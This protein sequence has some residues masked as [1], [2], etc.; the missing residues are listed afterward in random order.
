MSTI[1]SWLFGFCAANLILLFMPVLPPALPTALLAIVLNI[2]F[3]GQCLNRRIFLRSEQHAI[4]P[5][6]LFVAFAAGSIS[7]LVS[8]QSALP[9]PSV[10]QAL[11]AKPIVVIEG[12]VVSARCTPAYH[13]YTISLTR[14]VSH[15]LFKPTHNIIIYDKV[16]TDCI[17]IDS[18]ITARVKLK[19]SYAPANPTG[20]DWQK[21]NV[22]KGIVATGSVTNWILVTR[23]EAL[24]Q[25]IMRYLR[26]HSLV[27]ERWLL[28][29]IVGDRTQLSSADW[30]LLQSTATAHL[31]S[32]SGFHLSV[33]FVLLFMAISTG[34]SILVAVFMRRHYH[35]NHLILTLLLAVL[36]L[37]TYSQIAGSGVPVIRAWILVSLVALLDVSGKMWSATNKSLLMVS[38]II[39][40]FPLSILSA[41]F[42]L[43]VIA[44]VIIWYAMWR[45]QLSHS[46]WFI[47]LFK[48]QLVLSIAMM[49]V[50][51]FWFGMFSLTGILCNL[52]M[53][54]V[55]M[56][57]LP[58]LFVL[59]A[60]AAMLPMAE[61]LII[62][63]VDELMVGA[64]ALLT[65][66]DS[67]SYS[68]L[69]LASEPGAVVSV[70]IALLLVSFPRFRFKTMCVVLCC[71]P[72][73][74]GL[75]RMDHEQWQVHVFDAG[76]ATATLVLRGQRGIIIDT[77]SQYNNV[78]ITA[79][80]VVI[81]FLKRHNVIVDHV[82]VSHSDNDHS[83][84]VATLYAYLSQAK[85]K[86]VWTYPSLGCH[87]GVTTQWNQL[88]IEF[89]WP[90]KRYEGNDNNA[91]CVVRISDEKRAVLFPGDI[92]RSGE[93]AMLAA[94]RHTDFSSDVMIA[95]HHGSKTSSTNAFIKRVA[96]KYVIFTQAH[97]NRWGF[98]AESVIK[99]YHNH[100]TKM[101]E[102][103]EHGYVK[104][105]ISHS[106]NVQG[107]RTSIAPRWYRP[108][109]SQTEID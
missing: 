33:L 4:N 12:R 32:I 65:W 98:P 92:E 63:V 83:G 85:Q 47:A 31:F 104:V 42:F 72:V 78:A 105:T 39:F 16:D 95:P 5:L 22:S 82:I 9:D 19:R 15:R 25:Q 61:M 64:I 48:L 40:V 84:G 43:S 67:F 24:R 103:G 54:P 99:R 101:Y 94:H 49:P 46:H 28:A 97:N 29:L 27:S 3:S 14:P 7:A 60:I 6:S 70:F 13:R 11:T 62:Q 26:A 57:L 8:L 51:V 76:Q 71:L 50:T 55:V 77:G 106:V 45:W 86:V 36:G 108:A 23:N 1:T 100:Q 53:V 41:S 107:W 88:K 109:Y 73:A 87:S 35:I 20:P 30:L 90:D 44:V 69:G 79:K 93:Y 66:L 74:S 38:G 56:L 58:L 18:L 17:V 102:T 10:I 59:L 52:I 34:N 96:P 68:F 91:S 37:L 21:V 2:I 89:L 75:M 81:P 80:D